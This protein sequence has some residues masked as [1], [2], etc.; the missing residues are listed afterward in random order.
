MEEDRTKGLIVFIPGYTL[1]GVVFE[2]YI[3]AFREWSCE[4][5]EYHNF[6]SLNEINEKLLRLIEDSHHKKVV[7][8]G[9]SVG[10]KIALKAAEASTNVNSVIGLNPLINPPKKSIFSSRWQHR[11]LYGFARTT[12]GSLMRGIMGRLITPAGLLR[13]RSTMGNPT[14]QSGRLKQ[15]MKQIK[16]DRK[17]FND[18]LF[19]PLFFLL[20]P[21][22][23]S[24]NSNVELV[25]FVGKSDR[26]LKRGFS[27]PYY[28]EIQN[29]YPNLRVR[30]LNGGHEGF[31]EN[32]QEWIEELTRYLS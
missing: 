10:F 19:N 7:L 9:Q 22:P 1:S 31:L 12:S 28:E 11:I 14:Y 29:Q 24:L 26:L 2:G 15:S 25:A 18:R 4:I 8:I 6:R 17:D 27:M 5:F 20:E 23:I 21:S 3:E 30:Y 16:E 13:L 32:E